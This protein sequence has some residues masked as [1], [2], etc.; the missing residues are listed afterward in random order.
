MMLNRAI[1]ESYISYLYM[2]IDY[3]NGVSEAVVNQTSFSLSAIEDGYQ[4]MPFSSS[5]NQF[6][7][8]TY[9]QNA[10]SNVQALM[11]ALDCENYAPY[12]NFRNPFKEGLVIYFHHVYFNIDEDS[13]ETI[14]ST[15]VAGRPFMLL[16]EKILA[17]AET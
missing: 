13:R 2:T 4:A 7:L 11:P 1:T 14:P 3:E 5:F 8:E 6:I 15:G 10:C 12:T 16:M 17:D 9:F